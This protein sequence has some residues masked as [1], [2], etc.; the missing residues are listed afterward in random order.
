MC[1]HCD[2]LCVKHVDVGRGCTCHGFMLNIVNFICRSVCSG[3]SS[4]SSS[5]KALK[6][7]EGICFSY[8]EVYSLH[9][10]LGHPFTVHTPPSRDD[11]F[12]GVFQIS[13]LRGYV[14][15][16]PLIFQNFSGVSFDILKFLRGQAKK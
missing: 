9:C 12:L 11:N 14:C 8:S 5:G 1:K 10:R 2:C 4:N 16:H 3:N 15:C 13:F 6:N 7:S